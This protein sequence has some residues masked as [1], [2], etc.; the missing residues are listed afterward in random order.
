MVI[1]DNW[2]HCVLNITDDTWAVALGIISAELFPSYVYR[3]SRF[4]L[5]VLTGPF[6]KGLFSFGSF[7]LLW[8]SMT[9][10]LLSL[11]VFEGVAMGAIKLENKKENL[12]LFML[13]CLS[14]EDPDMLHLMAQIW[15]SISDREELQNNLLRI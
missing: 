3:A 14:S 6:I 5:E 12:V 15:P 8:F 4:P 13:N 9:Q 2:W 11:D 7:F 1:P 10:T